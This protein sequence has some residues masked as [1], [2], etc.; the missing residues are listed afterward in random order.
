MLGAKVL[1]E[2]DEKYKFRI[3]KGKEKGKE[4]D[5]TELW[6]WNEIGNISMKL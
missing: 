3:R 5:R 4:E 2:V 6:C 1:T